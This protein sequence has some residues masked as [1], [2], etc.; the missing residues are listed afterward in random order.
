MSIRS[1][2][3]GSIHQGSIALELKMDMNF[4]PRLLK[5]EFRWDDLTLLLHLRIYIKSY[6]WLLSENILLVSSS[7][8]KELLLLWHF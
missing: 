6:Y 7:V 4:S 1:L 5:K 3:L 2:L 8:P